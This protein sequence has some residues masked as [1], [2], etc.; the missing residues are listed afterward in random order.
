MKLRAGVDFDHCE[1]GRCKYCSPKQREKC[2]K[3]VNHKK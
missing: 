3:E 2:E 1:K